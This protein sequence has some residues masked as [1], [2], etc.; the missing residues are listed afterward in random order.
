MDTTRA[1]AI[2][3]SVRNTRPRR[4]R[5]VDEF[6]REEVVHEL[7]AGVAAA[8]VAASPADWYGAGAARRPHSS[9]SPGRCREV[10]NRRA[11]TLANALVALRP[12]ADSRCM[13]GC[14]L[15]SAGEHRA[16]LRGFAEARAMTADRTL[17]AIVEL[18]LGACLDRLGRRDEALA[19]F[20]AARDSDVCRVRIP[21]TL[22]AAMAAHEL[23]R[24]SLA[25]DH[26]RELAIARGDAR[27]DEVKLVLGFLER[28]VEVKPELAASYAHLVR[29]LERADVV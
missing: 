18:N 19:R 14:V 6:Y 8:I 10:A 26:V 5:A 1:A 27:R 29:E 15:L 2:L 28:R 20:T 12:D 21:A 11:A 13:R 4:R 7:R 23:G 25:R 16:A 3:E 24:A 22:F 17:L 9:T